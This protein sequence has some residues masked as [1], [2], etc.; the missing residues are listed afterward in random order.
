MNLPNRLTLARISLVPPLVV[1]LLTRVP[2]F[3]FWGVLILL[4]A[5]LTD[6]LDGYLARRRGQITPLGVLLDPVAD[7]LLISAA[8]IA[9]VELGLAPAWMVVIIVGRELAV[10]GMRTIAT[11]EGFRVVVSDLGKAKMVLQVCAASL[12]LLASR[13]PELRLAGTLAL[14]LV[15]LFALVSAVRYFNEFWRKLGARW[16]QRR[17]SVVVLQPEKESEPER[18]RENKNVV[19][20]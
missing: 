15:M 7:K 12:L 19:V 11:A 9:L 8:F 17:G 2:N 14:W 13:F 4:G 20:H 10:Q 5:A 6:W 1:V 18:E 3:E 16:H